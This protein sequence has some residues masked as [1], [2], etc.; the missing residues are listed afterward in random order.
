M[1]IDRIVSINCVKCEYFTEH[2]PKGAVVPFRR[3]GDRTQESFDI[4]TVD[5]DILYLTR[6][7][8]GHDRIIRNKRAN[9]L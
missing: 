6:F 7:G 3:L 4:M 2:K 8:A 5:D 9:W 1:R